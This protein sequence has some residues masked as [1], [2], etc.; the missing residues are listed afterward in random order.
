[1]THQFEQLVYPEG[2][3]FDL[4]NAPAVGVLSDVH[5]QRKMH[6]F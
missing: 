6:L 5:H 3:D 4:N 2:D 1:M